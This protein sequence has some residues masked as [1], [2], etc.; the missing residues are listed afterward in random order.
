MSI[1]TNIF[2]S[3]VDKIV[4]SVGE[5]ADNLFTSDEER[6][7]AKNMLEKIKADAKLQDKAMEIQYEAELTK[8]M[9]ASK[10]VIIAEAQGEDF[11]QRSWRPIA[12][13]SF[14]FMLV[15]NYVLVPYGIAFGWGIPQVEIPEG[16]F[17]LLTLGM[18]GYMMALGGKKVIE[19]SK[20][21]K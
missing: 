17:D 21:S 9:Q 12:M 11:M 5:A 16:V 19:S 2:S 7:K 6:L 14:T 3:G 10:E 4:D 8:R 20:W 18:G 15:N 13:L 1:W